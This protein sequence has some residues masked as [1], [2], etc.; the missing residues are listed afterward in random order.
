MTKIHPFTFPSTVGLCE[1]T[2]GLP[3]AKLQEFLQRFGYLRIPSASEEFA[4]VRTAANPPDANLGNF[5]VAT[6]KAL[7]DFQQFHGLP[8]TKALDEATVAEMSRPRCGFPDI[9]TRQGVSDFTA[10]GNRWDR[11]DLTYGFQ[12]FTPELTQQQVRDAIAAALNLWSQVTPLKFT[13]V[14]LAFKPDF[15]ISFVAGDHGDGSPFDGVGRV[16]AHAF[17]PPPNGGDVAG[18]AHFDE[19]ETWTVNIPVPAGGVDLITVAA[20]EFGHSLGLA[21]S[22]VPG[23]LMF[24]S[25]SGP[26]RFLAQ[27]DIDGIRSIYGSSGESL[28][29][30]LTSGV[31]RPG[32]GA[33][34][35]LTAAGELL[36]VLARSSDYKE[37]APPTGGV[38]QVKF[39]WASTTGAAVQVVIP[40]TVGARISAT[41]KGTLEL[42]G[43]VVST[44]EAGE[45]SALVN[46]SSSFQRD[47]EIVRTQFKARARGG[48]F[49]FFSASAQY[50]QD[51]TREH[52]NI[53]QSSEYAAFSDAYKKALSGSAATKVVADYY[54][55]VEVVS[56]GIREDIVLKAYVYIAQV[57]TEDGK[58]LNLVQDS[59]PLHAVD[60]DGRDRGKVATVTP[61]EKP[62]DVLA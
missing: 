32:E 11:T 40:A 14:S 45:Q 8:V 51:K 23:A 9:P 31:Q 19:A 30:V 61:A 50:Q 28:D 24:P 60:G 55:V 59:A 21:H 54:L 53:E 4:A 10:Q 56:Q 20:H 1:G 3:V 26:Q 36:M 13:E 6:A 18:D 22:S 39:G 43:K 37:S 15:V 41:L 5:D 17:Y 29:G 34:I 46:T 48:Y 58:V 52:E 16:L 7:R 12:D 2:N 35:L 57:T 42:E 25:Y 38:S 27:D 49:G 47:Y 44:L 33:P 62:L